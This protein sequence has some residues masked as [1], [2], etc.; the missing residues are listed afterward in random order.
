[1]IPHCRERGCYVAKSG[2]PAC[3]SGCVLDDSEPAPKP[4]IKPAPKDTAPKPAPKVTAPPPPPPPKPALA[5]PPAPTNVRPKRQGLRKHLGTGEAV[6]RD[7]IPPWR[8]PPSCP[9]PWELAVCGT[10]SGGPMTHDV[11][12]VDCH[13][14]L[15]IVANRS[16]F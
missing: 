11:A 1:M 10:Y 15:K 7:T 8:F 3:L 5:L 13:I 9:E 6:T 2:R 14:C 16:T 4:T 12:E